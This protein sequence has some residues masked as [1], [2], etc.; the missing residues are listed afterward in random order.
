MAVDLN[1]LSIDLARLRSAKTQPDIFGA[2]SHQFQLNPPL[3]KSKVQTFESEHGFVLPADY[4]QFTTELGNG[5]A[6]PY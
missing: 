6:G 1:S 5:G 2:K 4:R 3:P